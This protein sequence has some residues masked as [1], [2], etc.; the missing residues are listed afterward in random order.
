[1]DNKHTF[2]WQ[3]F[4]ALFALVL[5]F[6]FCIDTTAETLRNNYAYLF[7]FISSLL[8]VFAFRNYILIRDNYIII[9]GGVLIK[10]IYVLYTAIWTRQH[11]VIDFGVG[12]GH[13]GYIEYIYNNLSLPTGDPREK[14]AFFQPPLHHIISAVYMRICTHF[15]T[16][17]RQACENVQMLTF[18]YVAATVFLAYYI[19]KEL[20]LGHLGTKIVLLLVC[21]HPTFTIM[22][23]SINNDA[24]SLFLSVLSVYIVILWYK[25]PCFKL[26]VFLAFSIGGA[27][28]AK[29]SGGLVAPA[30]ASLFILKLI[31]DKEHIKKYILQFVTFGIIVFPLGLWWEIKNMIKYGMPFNYIPVVGE[32]LTQGVLSRIFDIRTHSIYPSL[33]SNGDAY[34]EYNV[35]LIMLKTSLFDDSN[36]SLETGKVNVIAIILFVSALILLLL[37][38]YATIKV[39][40]D[41][42]KKLPLE[43]KLLLGVLYIT[44]VVAYFSFALGSNNYSAG[45]FRYISL[46]IIVEA[47]FLGIYADQYRDKKHIFF[48]ALLAMTLAFCVSSFGTYFILGFAR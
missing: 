47:L 38:L 3:P 31:K 2:N 4:L 12:E 18:F 48:R 16:S 45:S 37:S 9:L 39:L 20:K 7:L 13:A 28:M 19:C 15:G 14:W 41:K 23:G 43:W 29:L 5:F 27:M 24:L 21:F 34:D 44:L 8:L 46:I 32:Q 26:I 6:S 35:L 42:E 33:I 36:L 1:M 40:R 11:D 22:S 10:L 25:N 17:F 30:V